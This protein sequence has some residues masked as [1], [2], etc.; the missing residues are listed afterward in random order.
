MSYEEQMRESIKTECTQRHSRNPT[1][2]FGAVVQSG[3]DQFQT[4][5]QTA[6][7]TGYTITHMSEHGS[8]H[9][10]IE[11]M[12]KELQQLWSQHGMVP[13]VLEFG[14][15]DREDGTLYWTE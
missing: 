10:A 14:D 3:D 4:F 7:V 9:D 1:Y 12:N 2:V 15:W 5:I 8:E 13:T 11:H 6:L